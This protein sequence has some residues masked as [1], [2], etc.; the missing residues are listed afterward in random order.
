[1]SSVAA[2]SGA[3]TNVFKHIAKS[4]VKLA[5][6]EQSS[7]AAREFIR[8]AN[9]AKKKCGSFELTVNVVD[10]PSIQEAMVDRGRTKLTVEFHDGKKLDF[11]SKGLTA[12]KIFTEIFTYINRNQVPEKA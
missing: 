2:S 5:A 11:A 12:S 8:R 9:G 3:V 6:F 1:M 10:P 7:S 4:N